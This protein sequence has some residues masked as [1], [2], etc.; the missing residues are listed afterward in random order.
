MG[1]NLKELMKSATDAVWTRLDGDK[2][3]PDVEITGIAMDSRRV[4]PGAFF[5]A[6]RG[7]FANGHHF[8]RQVVA[9]G[10]A[11]VAGTDIDS[12]AACK[13]PVAFLVD[14]ERR[15]LAHMSNAFH[16]FP[17][18]NLNIVG[19]TGTNGKTTIAH[20]VERLH[21]GL[22]ESTARI[23][24]L[25]VKIGDELI[26][27]PYTTPEA[28]ELQEYLRRIADS[29]IKSVAMEISS[30]GLA[31]DRSLGVR[32]PVAVFT[33]L[34]QDHLD[35]HRS[36]DDYFA[37][38]VR[39]FTEYEPRDGWA[40]INNDDPKGRYLI[41]AT[42][43]RVITYGLKEADL[44]ATDIVGTPSGLSFRL[45]HQGETRDVRVKL[46]GIFNVYNSLAAL[47]ALL[48]EGVPLSDTIPT[49]EALTGAPGRFEPVDE[50]QDFRVVVDYAHTP[51][52]L[53]NV[54]RAARSVT[55]NGRV[56]CV[57]GCGG[58]RDAGKRPLMG[59]AAVSGADLAFVTSDNPRSEDP[60]TIIAHILAGMDGAANYSCV[61]DRRSAIIEAVN[62]ARS[63]D[64]LVL[65]G[66]GHE[67]YQILATGKI[68][69]DD[70]EVARQALK[71]RGYTR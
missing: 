12:L 50:G 29:G 39:L 63:G 22:G 8:L 59:S 31:Q 19:I 64:T 35:F 37:A 70:R 34:T 23:G 44:R 15:A 20:L 1:M 43:R 61:P 3:I 10:A 42:K 2:E 41:D 71:D 56:L 9:A 17:S 7:E 14:N 25:G 60:D 18:K 6:T 67:D 47:G 40:V 28:P 5:V 24:T 57:F 45:I 38:K 4:V 55:P 62:A 48:A 27:M 58:D 30:H 51:D 46:A 13:A 16:G 49:L 11:A 26:S 21:A 69:F 66:K 65:A 32:C 36:M 53:T 52:A 54:L 33:N 68:H